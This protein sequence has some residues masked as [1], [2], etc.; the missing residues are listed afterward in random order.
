MG[1]SIRGGE[2]DGLAVAYSSSILYGR[3]NLTAVS[4]G[5]HRALVEDTVKFALEHRRYG[6]PLSELPTV[7]QKLGQLQS[8]LMTSR[9]VAYHAAH[10]LDEG[11]PCDTELMNAKLVN[12]E[13]SLDSARIAMEVHAAYG[14]ATDRQIERYVRDA[15]HIYAPAG[16]SDVQRLRLAEVALGTSKG[17]WSQRLAT[18]LKDGSA[19]LRNSVATRAGKLSTPP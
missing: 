14:L 8:Q 16:T 10:M 9:L 6:K 5:L 11:V 2:G 13:S 7:K 15:H 18:Q 19:V 1:A 3:P 4:L 12:V 17:Q